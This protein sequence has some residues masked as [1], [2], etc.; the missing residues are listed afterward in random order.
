MIRKGFPCYTMF[1]YIHAVRSW[2]RSQLVMFPSNFLRLILVSNTFSMYHS[3]PRDIVI[4]SFTPLYL[5]NLILVTSVPA[6]ALAPNGAKPS[7]DTNV[8]Y[9]TRYFLINFPANSD[10][11]YIYDG[12]TNDSSD[13][14]HYLNGN[15]LNEVLNLWDHAFICTR[16]TSS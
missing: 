4:I 12:W 1:K 13:M 8:Y 6:D 7:L 5:W 3:I 15:V 11:V 2:W 9:K 14:S 10:L 16:N